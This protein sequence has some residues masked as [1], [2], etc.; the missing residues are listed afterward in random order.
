ME[1][2]GEWETKQACEAV[3]CTCTQRHYQ[4]MQQEERYRSRSLLGTCAHISIAT[5][6]A[7][8]IESVDSIRRDTTYTQYVL[9]QK[10]LSKSQTLI[11]VYNHIPFIFERFHD[12]QDSSR[13]EKPS[14]KYHTRYSQNGRIV[15]LSSSSSSFFRRANSASPQSPMMV[16]ARNSS[17]LHRAVHQPIAFRNLQ[18]STRCLQLPTQ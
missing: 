5:K 11:S 18:I 7:P 15:F 4:N 8:I 2:P 14:W 13:R 6:Y 9:I 17:I 1:P 16:F 12:Q 3:Q 10:N